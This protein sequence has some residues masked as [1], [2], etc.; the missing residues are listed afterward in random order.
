MV[1]TNIRSWQ[2]RPC[3]LHTAAR[4]CRPQ[5]LL[6]PLHA[7]SLLADA[8]ANVPTLDAD[9][10]AQVGD[11]VEAAVE[12]A[13]EAA[14]NALGNDLFVFL[15]AS[16]FVVPLSRYLNITPVL[17]F[18]ALG[19]CI[20]PYGLG[21]FSNTEADVELGDF[22]ILFLLFVEGLNLSP[23]RI[24]KLGSFFSLGSVQILFS[25]GV[26]FFSTL[27]LGPLLLP[28]AEQFV[29]IDDALVR[30]PRAACR[31]LHH[32]RRRRPLIGLRAA[33]AQA[34]GLE[35]TQQNRRTVILCCRPAVA[36]L[37]VILPIAAGSGP[38]RG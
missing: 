2:F 27:W 33:S 26:I 6:D 38:D 7:T 36:P 24:K 10:G 28:L 32:R 13:G 18:I 20:G 22:G 3:T 21:L 11:A 12:S 5:L 1:L 17:G 19:A 25:M 23:E 37:L 30:P 34:E 8:V 16:V 4:S 31:G 29:P 14:V 35:Q 9:A 15:A